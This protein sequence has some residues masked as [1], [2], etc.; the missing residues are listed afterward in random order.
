M[1]V[2]TDPQEDEIED[3]LAF[4][5][6]LF[7]IGFVI[8]CCLLGTQFAFYPVNIL[9]GDPDTRDQFIIGKPEVTLLMIPGDTPFI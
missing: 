5:E 7:H 4:A 8:G 6:I 3:G 9:I 1:A 2:C